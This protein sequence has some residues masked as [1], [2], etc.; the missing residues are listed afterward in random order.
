M[1]LLVEPTALSTGLLTCGAITVRCALGRSGVQTNKREGDGATPAGTY[2]LRAIHYRPDRVQ[3]PLSGLPVHALSPDD[4]WCDDPGCADYN[5]LVPLPHAGSH[6][7]MWRDDALYDLV[8]V[9]GYNDAPPVRGLGSAIFL[10]LASAG[11]TPTAG[12]V[13]VA[14]DELLPILAA[15]DAAATIR[16]IAPR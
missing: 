16:I 5:K 6:E 15:C 8:V 3:R 12:C 2:P 1:Q 10:H 7:R 14:A 4:G 11:F 13:A 9:I